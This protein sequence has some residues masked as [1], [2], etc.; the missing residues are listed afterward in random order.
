MV[1]AQWLQDWEAELRRLQELAVLAA[2]KYK[3]EKDE[4]PV[5]KREISEKEAEIPNLIT[6]ADEVC[7]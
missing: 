3:L 7:S 1:A 2:S 4:L 5:L 6:E